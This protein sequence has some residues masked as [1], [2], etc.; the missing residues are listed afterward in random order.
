MCLMNCIRASFLREGWEEGGE[1]WEEGGEGWG[2]GQRGMGRREERGGEEG[3][4]RWGGVMN[5]HPSMYITLVV[6]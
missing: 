5:T 6:Q 3:G 1:G 2:G 4:E